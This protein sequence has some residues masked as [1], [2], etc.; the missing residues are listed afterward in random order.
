M[1]EML[2][3]T[4]TGTMPEEMEPSRSARNDGIERNSAILAYF[5]IPGNGYSANSDYDDDFKIA[6]SPDWLQ[7][8]DRLNGG[9]RP[10]NPRYSPLERRKEYPPALSSA[11]RV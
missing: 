8:L 1:V 5:G 3:L 10:L 4:G 2:V 11:S 9:S 6:V 7:L